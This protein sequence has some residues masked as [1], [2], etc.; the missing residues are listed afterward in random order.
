MA[1]KRSVHYYEVAH[2]T[3]SSVVGHPGFEYL[4]DLCQKEKGLIV[5]IG[6][7]EGS[8]LD[9][10]VPGKNGVGV[11]IN[12]YALNLARKNDSRFKFLLQKGEKIP[13]PDGWAAITYSTFVLEHTTD[14]VSYIGEMVRI[15]KPEGRLVILCPNFGAPNRRSP[16]S[17]ENP[18]SKLVKG[19]WGDFFGGDR[20]NWTKVTPKPDYRQIDDDTTVEPYVLSLF[21]Y[22]VAR[23]LKPVKVSSLWELEQKTTNPRKLL[24]LLLGKLGL[25][26]FKYW[27]PQIFL[28]ARK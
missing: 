20:L 15:T 18:F 10:L 19:L 22:L 14:P 27:G 13:L 12:Q 25:F 9:Y 11:E 3:L 26:P 28:V 1:T 23:E 5:D 4:K 8:R 24:F 6:C 17:I 16:N 7:G 2:N 21:R